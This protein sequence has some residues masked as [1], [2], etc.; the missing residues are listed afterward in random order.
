M[1]KPRRLAVALATLSSAAA[2]DA[3]CACAVKDPHIALAHGGHADLRGRDGALYNLV[4]APDVSVNAMAQDSL[5]KL[6]ELT[7]HGSYITQL[8]FA[9]R[10]ISGTSFRLTHDASMMNFEQWNFDMGSATCGDDV[11]LLGPKMAKECDD[12]SAKVDVSTLT[13]ATK[14]WRFK[15]AGQPVYGRLAGPHHRLDFYI[16]AL[17]DEAALNAHGIIGQSF[18]GSLMPRHGRLDQYPPTDIPADYYTSAMAEGAIEGIASDYEV[19]T[20][21]TTSFVYSRFDDEMS[22]SVKATSNVRAASGTLSTAPR[23][24]TT[25]CWCAPP[26]PPPPSPPPPL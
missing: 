7:V 23:R 20:P 25:T 14:H 22:T 12:L 21:F 26:A 18:D 17:V 6:G 10:T 9:L 19:A 4:S 16:E 13:I 1:L 8:H 3:E 24:R 5:F 15:V 11:L 2:S